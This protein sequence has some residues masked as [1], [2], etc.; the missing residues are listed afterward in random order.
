MRKKIRLLIDAP[1]EPQ[2]IVE[3]MR[4]HDLD[5]Q[6]ALIDHIAL[7]RLHSQRHY[8]GDLTGYFVREKSTHSK[9]A[10][11]DGIRIAFG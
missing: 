8:M 7:I 9:H 3:P 11:N 5:V 6:L 1:A 10:A 2:T 4:Q